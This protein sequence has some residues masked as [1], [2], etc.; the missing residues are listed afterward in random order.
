[1]GTQQSKLEHILVFYFY[2]NFWFKIPLTLSTL[3][4]KKECTM[5]LLGSQESMKVGRRGNYYYINLFRGQVF[6]FVF[7]FILL[8]CFGKKV[9]RKTLLFLQFQLPFLLHQ[10]QFSQAA[11]LFSWI[12]LVTTFN[13]SLQDQ[14]R[15]LPC[16]ELL[17]QTAPPKTE[18]E[19]GHTFFQGGK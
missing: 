10:Y 18:P 14:K 5:L 16:R 2:T 17:C 1:M 8:A 9:K 13:A 15:Y 12:K 3:S 6:V 4:Q 19:T 7:F 11:A